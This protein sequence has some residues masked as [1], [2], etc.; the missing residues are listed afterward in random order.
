MK[1]RSM[2]WRE[3]KGKEKIYIEEKEEDRKRGVGEE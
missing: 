2:R 3:A 1:G